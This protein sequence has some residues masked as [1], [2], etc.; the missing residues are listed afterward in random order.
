M[1]RS[2]VRFHWP[3]A[4]SARSPAAV[5]VAFSVIV[6]PTPLWSPGNGYLGLGLARSSED[7][8]EGLTR[9][10]AAG[11]VMIPG[12][13]CGATLGDSYIS[14]SV[15][16]RAATVGSGTCALATSVKRVTA[17]GACRANVL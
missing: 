15:S 3:T 12:V 5:T 17:A 4:M 6:A 13:L 2:I 14:S 9:G 10:G 7:D 11:R 1:S 8:G 16:V